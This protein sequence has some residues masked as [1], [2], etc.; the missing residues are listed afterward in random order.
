MFY[1]D[2]L[3]KWNSSRVPGFTGLVRVCVFNL[4]CQFLKLTC[5]L[6]CDLIMDRYIGGWFILLSNFVLQFYQRFLIFSK[7]G[8]SLWLMKTE[9]ILLV[10][11]P[12]PGFWIQMLGCSCC[13]RSHL[14]CTICQFKCFPFVLNCK[15][16][17]DRYV[18]F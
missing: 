12:I 14:F 15:F 8:H 9:N 17:M 16:D 5:S 13:V 3:V 4:I 10:Q 18:C 7:Q 2:W 11:C 6:D 1:L